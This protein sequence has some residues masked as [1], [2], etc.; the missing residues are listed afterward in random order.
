MR[1]QESFG[2]IVTSEDLNLSIN[3]FNTEITNI[4][5]YS[6]ENKVSIKG[7]DISTSNIKIHSLNGK[8]LLTKAVN[9]NN[10]TVDIS[11]LSSGIYLLNIDNKK[12]FKFVK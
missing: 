7:L 11:T 6:D 12:T 3:E 8:Q 10:N 1:A 4:S 9:S 5:I 2:K